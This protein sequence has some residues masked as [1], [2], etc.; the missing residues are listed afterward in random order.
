MSILGNLSDGWRWL[1]GKKR[2]A[3]EL[4]E[5]LRSFL[6]I[7]TEEKMKQGM[8]QKEARRTVRLERETLEATR[9]R[10]APPARSLLSKPCGRT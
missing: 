2:V 6:E 4:D 7:A 9:N 3:G 5:E 8:S 1:F 10:S